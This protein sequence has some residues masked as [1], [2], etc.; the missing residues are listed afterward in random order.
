MKSPAAFTIISLVAFSAVVVPAAAK[1]RNGEAAALAKADRLDIRREVHDCSNQVW[2][3]FDG[4]C[5]RN[6][7]ALKWSTI[8]LVAST[9]R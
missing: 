3:N 6:G 4:L 2:P 7:T 1:L 8:P 5:L 9:R